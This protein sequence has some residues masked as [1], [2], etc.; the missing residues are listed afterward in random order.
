M[1]CHSL[2]QPAFSEH[3]L[4]RP[5]GE[6]GRCCLWGS[7]SPTPACLSRNSAMLQCHLQSRLRVSPRAEDFPT[8]VPKATSLLSSRCTCTYNSWPG[9]PAG[10]FRMGGCSGTFP[11]ECPNGASSF[12]APGR[13][14]LAPSSYGPSFP[15]GTAAATPPARKRRNRL[16]DRTH[17]PSLI[18]SGGV[19]RKSLLK[20]FLSQ[21]L[22]AL[23]LSGPGPRRG[24]V[25]GLRLISSP[26]TLR[27]SHSALSE[28]QT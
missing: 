23:D 11:W 24:P 6:R 13:E 25:T 8:F 15:R 4:Y 9:P 20:L 5:W 2:P 27:E 10:M 7:Q 14:K 28:S 1:R 19:R 3:P 12:P 22:Q 26:L 18:K 21:G 17:I 16:W